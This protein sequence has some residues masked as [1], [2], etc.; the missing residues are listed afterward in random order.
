MAYKY[1][2]II[3]TFFLWL[4]LMNS[5]LIISQTNNQQKSITTTS[6]DKPLN[7]VL[8][9][10]DGMGLSQVSCIFFEPDY[11]PHFEKFSTIGLIKTSSSSQL[12]TDS[13]AGATAFATGKKTYNGAIGVDENKKSVETILEWAS[14]RNM[15]TG[16]IATSSITH[17]T[18]ASFFAHVENRGMAEEI[19]AYLPGSGVDFFA[20]GGLRFFYNRKDEKTLESEF[21]KQGFTIDTT[22]LLSAENLKSTKKYGFLLAEDGMKN[23]LEGR[24]KFLPDASKLALDYLSTNKKGFFLMIEGSQIDWGGHG[25]DADII[26]KEMLDFDETIGIVLD[27]AKNQGNTLVIVT[28]DHETGGYSLSSDGN[29]YNSIKATFSTTGHTATLIPVFAYGPGEKLFSGIYENT[30]IYD[31]MKKLL[32]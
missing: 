2:I 11:R 24:G 16:L 25:N 29:N 19:A 32:E 27:F 3:R 28:A 30:A 1:S 5:L 8:L 13:A 22:S 31:K 6:S 12:I 21:E 18:P 4:F 17:A 9:I 23:M 20:G 26:Q 10:G 7:I 15:K 14:Q